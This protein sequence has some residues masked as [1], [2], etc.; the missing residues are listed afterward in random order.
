MSLS[1]TLTVNELLLERYIPLPITLA[2]RPL[3][4]SC[5]IPPIIV[6]AV[7]AVCASKGVGSGLT[8]PLPFEPPNTVAFICVVSISSTRTV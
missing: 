5:I 6:S 2:V 8:S 3:G 7:T 1:T 4:N